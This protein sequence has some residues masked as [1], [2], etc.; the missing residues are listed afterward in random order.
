MVKRCFC[1]AAVVILLVGIAP[2]TYALTVDVDQIV[3]QGD[4]GDP[5]LWQKLDADVDFSW[6]DADTF[7]IAVTNTSI[8]DYGLLTDLPATVLLTGIGFTAQSS[9]DITGA[10]GAGTFVNFGTDDVDDVW[11]Y[12]NAPLQSGFFL[13]GATVDPAVTNVIATLSASTEISFSGVPDPA[14]NGP[15]DGPPHGIMPELYSG[16]AS[17]PYI[18]GT[19]VFTIDHNSAAF[20]SA[21]DFGDFVD[22]LNSDDGGSVVVSFGSPDAVVPEPATMLLLGTGLVGLAGFR[23]KF[24]K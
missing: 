2:A 20:L 3:Y 4:P 22:W 11:G 8:P 15:I 21:G 12:D 1:F 23:K 16:S 10:S 17:Q 18:D 7:T 19:A 9:M 24:K 6:V 14:A 5:L 13:N